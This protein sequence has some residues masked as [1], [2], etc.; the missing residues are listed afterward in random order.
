MRTLFMLMGLKSS[1]SYGVML[2]IFL[3]GIVASFAAGTAP[4]LIDFRKGGPESRPAVCLSVWSPQAAEESSWG[5][6]LSALQLRLAAGSSESS[7]EML[8]AVQKRL[9]SYPAA[10][11]ASSTPGVTM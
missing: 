1:T 2:M 6:G 4:A 3:S 9:M 11:S 7:G 10:L 5:R 8:S